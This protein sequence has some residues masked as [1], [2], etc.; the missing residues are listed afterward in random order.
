MRP[1]SS[2][3]IVVGWVPLAS[4]QTWSAWRTD[5]VFP[6]V[7]IR[8]RCAGYNEFAG[9]YLWDVQLRNRYQKSVDLAWAVEPQRLHG[10]RAQSDQA[11]AVAPGEAVDTH[12]TA[13]VDCSSPLV[14]RVRDVQSAGQGP[15]AAAPAAPPPVTFGARWRSRDPGPLQKSLT[16]QVFGDTISGAWSSPTFSFQVTTPF[17]KNVHGSVSI[18]AGGAR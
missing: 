8:Q 18:D 3:L 5:E 7:E 16:V 4:A 15:S 11:F 2:L 1:L 12:H 17:P 14:V 13:P 9:R 6:G 10:A